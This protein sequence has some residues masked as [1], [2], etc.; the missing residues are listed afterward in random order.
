MNDKK[1]AVKIASSLM[2]WMELFQHR[3]TAQQ[4]AE[5]K[6]IY[7]YRFKLS[8]SLAYHLYVSSLWYLA[9]LLS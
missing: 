3:L 5:L 9:I 8:G 6:S 7:V 1:T 2:N 4:S